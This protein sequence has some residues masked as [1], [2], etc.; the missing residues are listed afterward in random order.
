[1][2]IMMMV[3]FPLKKLLRS[4]LDKFLDSSTDLRPYQLLIESSSCVEITLKNRAI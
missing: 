4:P 3:K 2:M 1:M